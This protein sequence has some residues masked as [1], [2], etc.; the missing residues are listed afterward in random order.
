MEDIVIFEWTFTPKN[1][2]EEEIRIERDNY[3]IIIYDGL[4]E[5]RFS[6]DLYDEEHKVCDSLHKNLNDRFLGVQLL[7][8]KPYKLSTASMYRLHSDG[9]NDVTVFPELCVI[10]ITVEDID[11]VLK[12]KDGYIISDSGRER[13]EKKKK[14]AELAEI[15]S[16]DLVAT[17]LLAIYN[18]AVNDPDNELV[19]LYEIRDSLSKLFL[20]EKEVH[21][22][23]KISTSEWSRL[24]QLA[25]NEPLKQGRHRGKS[26]GRLRDATEEELIEARKIVRNFIEAYLVYLDESKK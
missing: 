3:K 25:N 10:T 23:L 14:L 4:V 2:F 18:A 5:V 13:I 20:G 1:F 19:H 7:T 12:D 8:H 9:R 17:S 16:S 26:A 11:L 6:S 22:T 24:G 21:K 15:Y